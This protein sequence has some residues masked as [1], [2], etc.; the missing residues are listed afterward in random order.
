[1]EPPPPPN[2][3]TQQPVSAMQMPTPGPVA[4]AP[5]PAPA[6]RGTRRRATRSFL[7]LGSFDGEGHL[8][9]FLARFWH[10]SQYM[11][12]TERDR[13]FHLCACLTGEAAQILWDLPADA[14][15]EQLIEQLRTRFGQEVHI[16]RYRA[17]LHA[18][19]RNSGESLQDLYLDI[20]RMAALAYPKGNGPL[21]Q[22][23][24]R[25]TFV[26]ALDDLQLQ[27]NVMEKEPATVEDALSI[28][29]RLEAYRATLRLLETCLLY[30][31]PSPR[32]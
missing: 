8:E 30:T 21:V 11:K 23:I 10:A 25:D 29:I 32:D 6:A 27:V 7:K 19:Q 20:R 16:E 17:A 22:Y 13:F 2:V 3:I 31:S 4:A 12:W 24:A 28:A 9:T 15:V 26:D 5:A 14:T 18:R 1:M